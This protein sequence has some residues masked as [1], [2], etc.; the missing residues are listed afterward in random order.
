[1]A[2][3]RPGPTFGATVDAGA[4]RRPPG[5][6]VDR[7]ELQ[8]R[9]RRFLRR[10]GKLL[11][12]QKIFICQLFEL[13]EDG[14]RRYRRAY[15]QTAK[16][17]GKTSL[18]AWLAAYQLAHQFSAIIPICASSYDQAELV[19]GDLRSTV[20]QSPTLSQV[21]LGFE[22]EIQVRDSPSK[23]FKVPAVA[24][25]S[26]GLRPSSAFFDE[27]HELIGPNRE[28]VH[29]VISNGLSKRRDSL[30]FN[31]STPGFDLET[32]AGRLHQHGLKVNSGE[33][34]DDEYL[35]VW[36]GADPDKFDLTDPDGLRAAIRAASPAADVFCNV[37]D[38]AARFHQ[39]PLN[40]FVRYHLG[41]WTSAAAAWL[42][43]GAFDACADPGVVIADGSEI[44]LA[45]D[46]SHNNDSTAVVAV[47]CGP[48]PHI[49]VIGCWEKPEGADGDDWKVNILDVEAAIKAACRRWRVRECAF[50]PFRW[51][52][53]MQQLEAD[54][55]PITEYPQTAARMAPST[56]GFYQAVIDRQLTHDGS[57]V[58]A[59]HVG[60]AVLKVD[61]RGQRLTKETTY[62]ARKI[63]AAVAA[64]MA[65]D[66]AAIPD[67]NDYDIMA[68]VM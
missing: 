16:G 60:N 54:G 42:P 21:M 53:T 12:F 23:A 27:I 35:F 46:G 9:T 32:V 34:V 59:R 4:I 8:A 33:V 39:V 64:V 6:R 56:A 65:F 58:L 18:A 19:F 22:G 17:Q 30:Q 48:V 50:D 13:R 67:P 1:M 63:D 57:P 2:R 10:T 61:A 66:R 52:R 29:L 14:R 49:F 24:G 40:E 11:P 51:Q 68:S 31:T 25:V 15:L 37:E 20:A 36:F 43:S 41:G 38:V 28:R 44:V 7:A 47:S 45:V 26:D 3:R 5:M 62:S 55:L